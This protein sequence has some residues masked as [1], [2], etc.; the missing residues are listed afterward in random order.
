MI[1]CHHALKLLAAARM[2]LTAWFY[3]LGKSTGAAIRA[4]WRQVLVLVGCC[5]HVVAVV[6]PLVWPPP[7]RAH[8]KTQMGE[9]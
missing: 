2:V 6:V 1:P 4:A 8:C 7:C 5:L 9:C 3:L